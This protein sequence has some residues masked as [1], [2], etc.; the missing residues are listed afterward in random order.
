MIGDSVIR[1]GV[2]AALSDAPINL[3][4]NTDW[5]DLGP[6]AGSEGLW[7]VPTN[8]TSKMYRC[9]VRLEPED[10]GGYSA[11]VPELPGVVSEGDS[12]QEAVRNVA[13]ALRGALRTY[14]ESEQPIP[15]KKEVEPLQDEE[16]RTWIVV[17]V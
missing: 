12:E 16:A 17:D 1:E 9:E 3:F 4:D 5:E 6:S 13:E 10:D 15:W 2:C 8:E 14:Q 11:Y 7:Y